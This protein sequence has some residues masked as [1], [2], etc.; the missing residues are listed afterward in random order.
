FGS[1]VLGKPSEDIIRGFFRTATDTSDFDLLNVGEIFVDSPL[2]RAMKKLDNGFR[3]WRV[4]RKNRLWWLIR[5]PDSFDEYVASLPKSTRS[6]ITRDYRYCERQGVDFRVLH[7][8]EDIVP[9]LE[10][11]EKVSRLTYQWALGLGTRN[12]EATRQRFV[13]LAKHGLLRCYI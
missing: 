3:A 4:A 13:R 2:Y 11:A 5:L 10:Q 9:F 6:H 8:T 12:D 7:R 1:C